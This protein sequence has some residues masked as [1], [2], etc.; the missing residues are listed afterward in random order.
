MNEGTPKSLKEAVVVAVCL[1]PMNKIQDEAPLVIKDFLSQKFG[2]ALLK[3]NSQ[4]EIDVIKDLWE[5]IIK[6]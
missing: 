4:K 2:A 1:R 3:A 5:Q 6:E